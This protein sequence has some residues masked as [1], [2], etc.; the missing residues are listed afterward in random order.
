MWGSYINTFIDDRPTVFGDSVRIER[1][2]ENDKFSSDYN[3]AFTFVSNFYTQPSNH[4]KNYGKRWTYHSFYAQPITYMILL[5]A[6]ILG[7]LESPWPSNVSHHIS[8]E[9]LAMY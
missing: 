4:E 3:T 9:Y 5:R 1:M 6:T 8:K 7:N 2:E